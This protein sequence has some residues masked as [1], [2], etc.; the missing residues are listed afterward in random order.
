MQT[1]DVILQSKDHK[2][3]FDLR[4]GIILVGPWLSLGKP[5]RLRFYV[6]NILLKIL[7]STDHDACFF[8]FGYSPG[9]HRQI[10][11]STTLSYIVWL[12]SKDQ[13]K[14]LGTK[15]QHMAGAIFLTCPRCSF[16]PVWVLIRSASTD[17][18]QK[19]LLQYE[20]EL[21]C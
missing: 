15:F 14:Q 11:L 12:Q 19:Q 8:V 20:L 21:H 6:T 17:G 9:A 13:Q 3:I 7:K 5:E 4:H 18:P 10:Y 2:Q 1:I 16:L